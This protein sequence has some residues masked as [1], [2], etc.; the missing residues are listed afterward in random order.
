MS[1]EQDPNSTT[2]AE[3]SARNIQI[4]QNV[5]GDVV[6]SQY[7]QLLDEYYDEAL[8]ASI[9]PTETIARP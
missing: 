3:V 2:S 8:D 5:F 1:K 4:S 7:A 9:N 6:T